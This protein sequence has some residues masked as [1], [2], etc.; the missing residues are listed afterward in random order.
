MMKNYT[1][2]IVYVCLLLFASCNYVTDYEDDSIINTVIIED[3]VDDTEIIE[4]VQNMELQQINVY[5]NYIVSGN[6]VFG[7]EGIETEEIV[8]KDTE[9]NILSFNDFFITDDNTI[10]FSVKVMEKGNAIPDTDPVQYEPVE[11]IYHFSPVDGIC[12]EV[13]K[14][15]YPAIP[16]SVF[17]EMESSPFKIET[18]D[19]KGDDTSR[20][21]QHALVTGYQ[22]IDGYSVNQFGI[23]FSVPIT[24]SI[25]YEGIYFYAVNGNIKRKMESGRI[26]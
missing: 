1:T 13:D 11:K 12:T 7:I 18:F 17:I 5:G 8:L 10:Y 2:I 14:S 16:E 4:E 19:Y 15:E 6:R 25:R 24:I 9:D 3:T 21:Y 26:Y 23:W 22:K 20:V